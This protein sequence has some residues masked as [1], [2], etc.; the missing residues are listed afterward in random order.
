MREYI[1]TLT[2]GVVANSSLSAYRTACYIAK[3]IHDA[4]YS[5]EIRTCR[6]MPLSDVNPKSVSP[7]DV[8]DLFEERI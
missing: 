8:P 4:T 7:A 6:V 5:S 2:I 3:E 1:V